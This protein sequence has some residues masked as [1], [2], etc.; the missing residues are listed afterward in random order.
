M[1]VLDGTLIKLFEPQ[2]KFSRLDL[3][4]NFQRI[5]DMLLSLKGGR[6][7][8]AYGSYTGAKGDGPESFNDY[9]GTTFTQ[10]FGAATAGTDRTI[11]LPFEPKLLVIEGSRTAEVSWSGKGYEV[12]QE[13]SGTM[14]Y[15][16][17]I[18]LTGTAYQAFRQTVCAGQSAGWYKFAQRLPAY[19]D[20]YLGSS[21]FAWDDTSEKKSGCCDEI[22][23]TEITENEDGTWSVVLKAVQPNDILGMIYHWVA[24]G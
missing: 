15:P 16:V 10:P 8:I 23:F 1:S 3:N 11:T 19:K 24:F 18:A 4:S 14:T 13:T 22:A 9:A 2:D 17:D 20:M 6:A 21:N 5:S 7:K 12:A